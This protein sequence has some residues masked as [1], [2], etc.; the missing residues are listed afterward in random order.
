MRVSVASA[1]NPD[2]Y[3]NNDLKQELRQKT[4]SAG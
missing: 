4:V 2:E 3:L 1:H